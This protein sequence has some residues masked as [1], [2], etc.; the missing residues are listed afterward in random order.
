MCAPVCVGKS[1]LCVDCESVCSVVDVDVCVLGIC[2]MEVCV[3]GLGS[4]PRQK[5]ANKSV[6]HLTQ[7]DHPRQASF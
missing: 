6:I 4:G 1:G 3:R 5:V 7:M 2:V